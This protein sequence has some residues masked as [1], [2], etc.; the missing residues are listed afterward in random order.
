MY[1]LIAPP[2]RSVLVTPSTRTAHAAFDTPGEL[3]PHQDRDSPSSIRCYGP[4]MRRVII[5]LAA[6]V[7][8]VTMSPAPAHSEPPAPDGV[9][10]SDRRVL[11]SYAAD[12]WRSM[13]A[14]LDP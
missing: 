9:A 2:S 14:M 7:L 10:S 13:T 4:T 12:T 6:V 3:S 11:T 8:L 5:S 1:L